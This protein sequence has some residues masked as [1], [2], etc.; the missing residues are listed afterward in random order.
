MPAE[1]APMI[2]LEDYRPSDWLIDTVDL[3]IVLDATKTRV[4]A[5]LKLRPNPH[6]RPGAPLV[7][8]GDE[9]TLGSIALDD[10]PLDPGLYSA[11]PQTLT[12]ASPPDRPFSLRLETELDPGANTKLMGLY[13]SSGVYCTQCEADGF[14]RITYFLDRPD[15]MS[16]YTVRLEAAK[17][18]APVL[19]ANGNLVAAAEL[20]GGERHFAVWHD[21]HPKPAYLFAL[22]GGKLDHVRQP[23]VTA[24]GR[25]VELA[26]YVEPGKAGRAGW[27]LD[28]LVRCM[29]WDERVF[30]R[31][32][33]LD[34]FNV[35]AVSDFNMGAM[36]NKGLNIFND[37]YVLADPQT[38]SDGDY[39][40][41]E[42]I[43]AH[44]YFHNWTGN[45]ITC[46]DW[47]QL[48]LKEGLT[49]FRDQE[50]SSDE[51][52]RP[53]KRIADVRTLRAT[54]FSE[55]AGPLAHP[56]RPRAYK[57]INNFY[58]PT[59]YEKGAE[60]IRMLKVLI[61]DDAFE[62]GMDLYFERCDGT[63]AT[64][65]EFLDCFI[66]T[67]GQDLAHFAQWY[68][69]AGTP[70]VVAA[71]RYDAAAKSYTLDLAQSTPRTPGQPQKVPLVIPVALGLVGRSGDLPLSS[72]SPALK[73]GGVVVLDQPSLS[74]T[75]TGLSEAPAPSLL[76]GFSAPVRLE[77]DLGD[78]ELLRLFTAD[79]DSFN[80]WQA[81]QT[82]A[83]RALVRAGASGDLGGLDAKAGELAQALEGFLAG[84]ATADPAFAAQALRLP[85]PAD[86]AREIGK[87]V[88]PDAVFAAH[89][90]LA[91]E[92]GAALA[93]PLAALHAGLREA[94]PYSPAAGPAGRRALRNEALGLLALG[95]PAEASRLTQAQ[96]ADADNLTDRLAALAAMTL[97][98][99][100]AR[101]ELIA[102]FASLYAGEP[103][104]LDK[105]LMAQALI[106][107]DGTLDRVRGLMGHPAFS[108][109]NPN[110]V[111]AL[112]GGFA[113]N[114]TQF[115]RADGAG[116]G[117]I[118]GIV[119]ELDRANPQVASRLLGSFKSWRMLEDGRRELAKSALA[120][121]AATPG[122]SRDVADIAAR[123]L[124]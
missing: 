35:V 38:A 71:G 83:T 123:S 39:A 22:V 103:L 16:V 46:R 110:R 104:V 59:V 18:E 118:A 75:F 37:K 93:G 70:T 98:P 124:A 56:V 14:R 92:I 48:C 95:A 72:I 114:L 94:G 30:G 24:E 64:I 31:N 1:D 122:L 106:P 42:A 29:R 113:A 74:V 109:G 108:P 33:D 58:T 5:L 28:S 12:L 105:W 121:V 80:R 4:R 91:R 55:D 34:V 61:G 50:F 43:I 51:R 57:E 13:R 101:E 66:E 15:V 19:L 2:R 52:S 82:V 9:L 7:L 67:S 8:D 36:E 120:M 11:T 23:Y 90:K 111:R 60:V 41:I 77:L 3:D 6:G 40:S 78:A 69:Q 68:E 87:D 102:R 45:R 96:F 100:E 62:R 10:V 99:G 47:F 53:V 115:N 65:E 117:F 20:P 32:Y 25:K 54:Q 84:P 21:P 73:A 97:I 76:R 79:S 27:A 107:E 89:R 17:A 26:V 116:Y 49:V 119:I 86:I 63:A 85:G 88:D 44:E 112:I 81:L